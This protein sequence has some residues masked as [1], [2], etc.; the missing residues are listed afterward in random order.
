MFAVNTQ[1][2]GAPSVGDQIRGFG[3]DN[4]G[5]NGTLV[6]FLSVQVFTLTATQRTQLEQ[7]LLAF[8]SNLNPVVG[9]QVTVTAAN[10][11]RTDVQNRL[12]LLVQRAGITT[13]RPECELV[14]RAVIAG[15]SR[16]WVMNRNQSFVP[17]ATGDAAVSLQGLLNQA[18]QASAAVT[19]TCV[20][21][22]NGTR[23]G[24]DR[25]ADGT[26]DRSEP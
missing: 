6:Q 24:I 11:G 21:P 2:Q 22:G 4:S 14:A 17:D 9:Q 16:G 3:F 7:F 5:A 8:P 10:A 19:F 13:P 20:P 18:A 15:Q 25:D 26:P 1:I 23:I 12:N